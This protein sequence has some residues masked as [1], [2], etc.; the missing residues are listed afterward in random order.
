MR[1]RIILVGPFAYIDLLGWQ[2]EYETI[3]T[4]GKTIEARRLFWRIYW[5]GL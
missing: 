2:G 5:V 4:K 3:E 1:E